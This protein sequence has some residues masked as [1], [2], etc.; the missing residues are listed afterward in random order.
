MRLSAWLCA[1]LAATCA[2]LAAETPNSSVEPVRIGVVLAS[3]PVSQEIANGLAMALDEN[4]P[5]IAGRPIHLLRE[6]SS[7]N[8]EVAV[9]R[10]RKLIES[11]GV[12]VL[13]GPVTS[14]EALALRDVAEAARVPL[15]VPEAPVNAITGAKCS[16]F[17][18]RVSYA[19]SQL[20]AALAGYLASGR[21]L[22]RIYMIAADDAPGHD[23]LGSFRTAYEAAGGEIVGET[24]VP[25][26]APDFAPYLVKLRLTGAELAFAHFSG[27]AA[28][29][30]VAAYHELR[31][32]ASAKLA[33]MGWLVSPFHRTDFRLDAVVGAIGA[34][35]YL[36]NDADSA[37]EREFVRRFTARFGH[38]PSEHAAHGYDAGRLIVAAL[39]AVKGDTADRELF[40]EALSNTPFEG[41]R[42]AVRIDPATNNVVEDILVVKNVF[43]PAAAAGALGVLKE[44]ILARLPAVAAKGGDCK[45]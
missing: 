5:V 9:E 42:G 21:K 29:R 17:L 38:L 8:P 39:R 44:D 18:V 28:E 2:P 10:A 15:V 25:R 35:N 30:F 34:V 40:A 3:G 31:L 36:P 33:G 12:D 7:G 32:Q 14:P 37:I 22:P 27:P 6:D 20:A 19:N 16:R 45:L 11:D 26:N 24:Y 41:A 13:V 4:G 1:I 23:M 43:A